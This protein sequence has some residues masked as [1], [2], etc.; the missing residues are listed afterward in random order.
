MRRARSADGLSRTAVTTASR[1]G[2]VWPDWGSG[3]SSATV[4][5]VSPT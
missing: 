3:Q 2:A 4:S 1:L 5:A